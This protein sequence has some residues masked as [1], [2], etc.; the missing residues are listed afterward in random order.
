[1]I[2]IDKVADLLERHEGRMRFPY[3]D[4][5]GLLTIGIGFN[6]DDEGLYPEEMDF[7][8]HNRIGKVERWLWSHIPEFCSLNGVRQAVL[9]DMA[10][11]MGTSR[12]MGFVLMFIAISAKDYEDAAAEMLDSRWAVQVG[13]RAIRL[14]NM[15]RTG[16]WAESV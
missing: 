2:D 6:L 8:L 11:N 5:M 9:V 12:L 16:R 15:M 4:S 1:M 14:S 3:R 10:F 13:G 7:I